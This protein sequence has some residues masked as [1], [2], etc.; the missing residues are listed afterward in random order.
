MISMQYLPVF[1]L[2]HRS[3]CSTVEKY[4]S[5]HIIYLYFTSKSPVKEIGFQYD[6]PHNPTNNISRDRYILNQPN[7]ML[8]QYVL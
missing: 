2:I 3:L 6:T 4:F 7:T 1:S 8:G 5:F